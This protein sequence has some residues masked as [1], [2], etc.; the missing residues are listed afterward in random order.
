MKVVLFCGGLGMRLRELTE[1][2][3]KPMVPVGNQ[4][5]LWHV[6]QYYSAHGH[7]DFILCLGYKASVIKD[8]FLNYRPTTY[9]NFVV[10]GFGERIEILD[11]AQDDWRV[12]LIDTGVWRN[13]G[14]RLLAV[15]R[16]VENEP[17]FLANYS[18]GVTDLPL[19]EMME[20]FENS[21]K[22]AAFLAVRPTFSYHLVDMDEGGEVKAFRISQQSDM[23]INGGYMI[24]RREIFDYIK[25]GEELVVEPFERLIAEGKLAAYR[26]NGFWA[27][28]DTL[29]DKQRLEEMVEK[30]ETPWLPHLDSAPNGTD[31]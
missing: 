20:W 12:A 9:S 13:I 27:S 18:D 23:W 31:S 16:H 15:R 29:K 24:L 26:Y 17:M 10:S 11:Q 7:R 1:V 3:P 28:L 5:I 22:I 2:I 6:M 25:P 4:P 19:S 30:G 14:E 8:Y 21:G